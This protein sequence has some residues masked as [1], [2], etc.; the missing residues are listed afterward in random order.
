LLLLMMLRACIARSVV[1]G[2]DAVSSNPSSGSI[3]IVEKRPAVRD[4]AP[5]PLQGWGGI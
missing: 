5:R 2:A 1:A 4:T 3:F